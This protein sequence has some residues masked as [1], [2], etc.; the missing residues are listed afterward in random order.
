MHVHLIWDDTALTMA[1][2]PQALRRILTIREKD[3]DGKKTIQLWTE[4]GELQGQMVC[5]TY[6]G[7]WK[8]VQ[9][10]CHEL[11]WTTEI[12]D[13]RRPFPKPR[14]DLTG[15]FRF[16]Q[17]V[18]LANALMQ[19]KS[20][21]I[22]WPTRYG[23]EY[24]IMNICRAYPMSRT[25][26]TAPG[27]DLVRQLYAAAKRSLPE[28]KIVML[29]GGSSK[30]IQSDDLTICSMDSLHLCDFTGTDLLIP[31]EVHAIA[32]NTR[33]PNFNA[34]TRARRL[35]VGA[36]LKGRFDQRDNVIQGLIG[37]VLSEITYRQAVAEGAI[38]PIVV[39]AIPVTFDPFFSKW[40]PHA[41]KV[42]MWQNPK[43][44]WICRL[45]CDEMLPADWQTLLF[46]KN[47]DSA[48]FFHQALS[49]CRWPVAMAKLLTTSGRKL[50]TQEI[51]DS[52]HMRVLCSDIYVQ[53]MTFS[54]M[55]ALVNLGGGGPYTSVIQKPGRLAEIRPDLKKRHGV[56][57]DFFPRVS[58]I[59]TRLPAD[60]QAWWGP[61]KD[62]ENRLKVY[63]ETG[64]DVRMCETLEDV[65][66]TMKELTNA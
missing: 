40:R 39:V 1:P 34:F 57:V 25:V 41:M 13:R 36:T 56:M 61:V 29:G 64:Y 5:M 59:S 22:G 48:N 33:I 53:G 47:E 16:S 35:G 45:L 63:H 44:A 32:T 58:R 19:D 49:N 38:C 55:R 46:I 7:F 14:I 20:G 12:S 54:D 3:L 23:K 27:A 6:Q 65:R 21:L 8:M 9:E 28:R 42:V 60:A 50:M 11:G 31:D 37:P 2:C 4:V 17:G 66:K 43:V 18:S 10:K 52:T 26:I 51:K 62:G 15:G 24:A 30:R